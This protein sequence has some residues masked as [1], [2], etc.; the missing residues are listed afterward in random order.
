MFGN[1]VHPWAREPFLLNMPVCVCVCV[2]A[3]ARPCAHACMHVGN[4]F[5]PPALKHTQ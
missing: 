4:F 2:C 5:F 3:R 1:F